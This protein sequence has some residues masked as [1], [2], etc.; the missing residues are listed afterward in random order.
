MK[1]EKESSVRLAGTGARSHPNPE[2]FGF[3]RSLSIIRA[4]MRNQICPVCG[5]GA[6]EFRDGIMC[7]SWVCSKG[8]H[9]GT[10]GNKGVD[11]VNAAYHQSD[12][13]AGINSG[14]GEFGFNN[15]MDFFNNACKGGFRS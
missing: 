12:T 13:T 4:V 8:I 7:R 1:R 14:D 10:S 15:V 11:K 3:S 9:K 5:T 2:G 6:C